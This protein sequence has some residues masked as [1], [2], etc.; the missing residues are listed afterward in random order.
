MTMH[1]AKGME[2]SRVIL[3]A[4]NE[5]LLPLGYEVANLPGSEAQ[6]ALLRERSLLYVAATR[7]RDELVV[8]WS[9]TPSSLL[10][11]A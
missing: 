9:G 10:L 6:D 3:F 1:R 4:V 11:R 5:G 7:A 2:F 8:S